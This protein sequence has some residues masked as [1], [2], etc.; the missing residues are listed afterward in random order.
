MGGGTFFKVGGHKCTSKNDRNFWSFE[1]EVVTSQTL[2]YDLITCTPYEGLNYTILDKITVQRKRVGEPPEIQKS[3]YWG[4]PGH[5]RHSGSSYD[6][7]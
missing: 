6:L 2:K 1:L 3:C 5:Q 7:F 4:D